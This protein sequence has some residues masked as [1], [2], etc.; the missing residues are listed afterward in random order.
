MNRNWT[1]KSHIS[2]T[3][4]GAVI[5]VELGSVGKA[6]LEIFAEASQLLIRG[7]HDRLGAFECRLEI[8]SGHSIANARA[9][10]EDGI[11][12]IDLPPDIDLPRSRT[13]FGDS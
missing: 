10:F 3:D 12:H 11:L 7:Q 4:A 1:P 13:S 5:E 8:P 6:S 2:V 9:R